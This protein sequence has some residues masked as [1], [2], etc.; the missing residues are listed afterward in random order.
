IQDS[1]GQVKEGVELVNQAGG[2]LAQILTSI[3]DVVTIVEGISSASQEQ[4]LGVQE[5]NRS[6]ADMDEMTQQNSALVEQSTASAR[7]LSDQARELNKTIAF[8]KTGNAADQARPRPKMQQRK[9]S[10]ATPVAPAMADGG[11]SD[12]SEF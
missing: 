4:A 7:S 2:A 3:G 10:K 12:W 6:I 1:N 8:F 5:I 11:H 9:A